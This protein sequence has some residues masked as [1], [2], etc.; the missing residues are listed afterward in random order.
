MFKKILIANRGEIA[1]RVMRACREMGI[2]TVAVFSEVDRESLH[3][4]F[5][6]EAYPIGPAP[7]MES[8]L[9]IDKIIQVAH[10]SG[11][12]AVHPGYG[13]LSENPL[14]AEACRKEGIIFIGPSHESMKAMGN[15]VYARE[16]MKRTGVPV[17]P[18]TGN[19]PDDM[20]S[21][22]KIA[23]ELGY[24]VM[25][26]ASAGGGGKGMRIVRDEGEIESCVRG[27]RSEAGSA[28]GDPS[29]YL[30]R[31]F[32]AP[33]HIEV[34][35]LGDQY[36]NVVHLFERECSIQRR[37]QK[38]IEES[39][40]VVVDAAT[41]EK[42]GDLAVKAAEAVQYVA[43][44]T[45]EFLRDER[46]EFYFMEMNT[47][48]QVEHP[49][50]EL[51]AGIDLVKEMIKI[52]AGERLSFKQ[53]DLKMRGSAIE[54]RIYAED[55]EHAFMPSPGKVEFIRAPGGPGVRDD[56]GIY[57]GYTVPVYYDPLIA[58]LVVWGKDRNEA[59]QR[60]RRALDEYSIQGIKTTIPF[61]RKV[62]KHK[63][64]IAG[65]FDTSFVE[66]LNSFMLPAE[67]IHEIAIIGAAI[68]ALERRRP[69]SIQ[70]EAAASRWKIDG[71]S[72]ALKN[73]L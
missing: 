43:A 51:V 17:I 48:L 29:V 55:S 41:R 31:Y 45:I 13:F 25:V 73:R 27:A 19:L 11:A 71:R 32:P 47:R 56:S 6:D 33:R 66:K 52:A 30:E 61:H 35:I 68:A 2:R 46:G 3:I 22:K 58:K 65:E 38:L 15:K 62:L 24:P 26:K 49:V 39:P 18:G 37:H 44:G 21:I 60:M 23:S 40:S 70:R 9:R 4:R 16:L 20:A 63:D 64:F 34:Q 72:K 28:F 36:G 7:S 14:F 50:T 42:L 10:E 57:P 8:Y 12:E 69:V 5:A 67:G 54:C 1:V 59:L 53:E